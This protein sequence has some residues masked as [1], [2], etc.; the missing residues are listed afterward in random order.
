MALVE[1]VV[2]EF[3][4]QLENLLGLPLGDAVLDRAGDETHALLFHLGTDLLAHR[5]A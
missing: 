5:A 3:R 2:G 4:E 1:A